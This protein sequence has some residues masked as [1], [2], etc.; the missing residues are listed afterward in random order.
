MAAASLVVMKS[1]DFTGGGE[2]RTPPVT[3]SRSWRSFRRSTARFNAIRR[4]GLRPGT[5]VTPVDR[6]SVGPHCSGRCCRL[7]VLTLSD[8]ARDLSAAVDN[9][10]S[11]T[12]VTR[13]THMAQPLLGPR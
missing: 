10:A 2:P 11:V 8:L 12:S 7:K 4:A 6:G 1:K 5:A 3:F 13:V 9:Q